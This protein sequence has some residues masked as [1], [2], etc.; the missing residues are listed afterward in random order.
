MMFRLLFLTLEYERSRASNPLRALLN[1]IY[2]LMFE[3]RRVWKFGIFKYR[4]ILQVELM[5]AEAGLN[6]RRECNLP[7]A[8]WC[9]PITQ[10]AVYRNLRS[11]K[12]EQVT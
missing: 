12:T 2:F 3:L 11:Y 10:P 4:K 1:F 6:Y 9:Q 5:C 7:Q 8:P